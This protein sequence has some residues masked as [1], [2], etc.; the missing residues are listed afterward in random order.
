MPIRLVGAGASISSTY[1]P[2][3]AQ[4]PADRSQSLPIG[5]LTVLILIF[6][7]R[8][9]P[10]AAVP[11]KK[12]IE[13]LDPLGTLCF[14][15]S[16]IC[17][18]LALQWGGSTYA[19]SNAR[20]IV[21]FVLSAVLIAS[22][23]GIQFWKKENATVRLDIAKNRTVSLGTLYSFCVGGS[24]FIVVY[25]LPL[26]FQA[27]QHVSAVESGIRTLPL[28][29]SL[30][31][32]SISAGQLVSKFGWY[33]P[34]F[35]ASGVF[36]S[37]GAGLLMTLKTDSSKGAWIGYQIIFGLGLGFGMQQSM[38]AVQAVVPKKDISMGISII[39]LGLQIG[40]AVLVCVGQT[41][42]NND[43]LKN[44][45]AI[46]GV[47]AELILQTGATDLRKVV[48]AEK[49]AAVLQ[50]YNHALSR[51]YIVALVVCCLS[52]VVGLGMPWINIR[53]SQQG[54]NHGEKG[55]T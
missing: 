1:S 42:F 4:E 22:F 7:L 37:I 9:P 40:G 31:V 55:T 18:L 30:V 13:Q 39:V 51:T 36:T 44:L 52:F 25:F 43:L 27:V 8:F 23:I 49:M 21:L 38:V 46:S 29:L 6:I 17:L 3:N 10:V 5:A 20:I 16:I 35:I 19:W 54:G 32:G 26:W 41:I 45:D 53:R 48:P 12:Q 14:L 47:N 34:F 50:A 24:M 33:N 28:V 15:P 2:L 11:F